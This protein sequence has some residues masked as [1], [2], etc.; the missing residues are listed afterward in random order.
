MAERIVARVRAQRVALGARDIQI[1]LSAG[2]AAYPDCTA[3][4]RMQLFECADRALYLA[5]RD[6]RDRVAQFA[7]E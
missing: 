5:K 7:A 6:G 1:T 4:T 2:V 3:D